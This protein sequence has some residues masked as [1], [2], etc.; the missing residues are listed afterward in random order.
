[1]IPSPLPHGRTARRLEWVHLPPH[2]RASVEARLG[3]PVTEAV[4]QD[5]GFTPGLA[6]VLTC[7]DGTRHF[8]KAASV[9]AQ[10][11]IAE[12]YR[13]EA[14][15]LAALPPGAPAARLAWVEDDAD[16]VVLG[17]EHVEGRAPGRPWTEG[18]LDAALAAL[19]EAAELLTPAPEELRLDPFAEEFAALPAYW[20]RIGE[21]HPGL[22]HLDEAAELAGGIAE[23][24]G[25]DTVVHTDVRDDN[26][27]VR[28]DGRVVLCDWNWPVLGAPWID[29]VMLLIGPRGDGLDV[30]RV[31]TGSVL[32][33]DLPDD[34]VDTLIALVTGHFL[35]CAADPVP[36]TSPHLRTAQRWQGVVCWDWLCERRGWANDLG[37]D[38]DLGAGT[39]RC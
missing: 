33:R 31:L 25:G 22:A 21:I 13:E 24:T 7:A 35:K 38:M 11:P 28:P 8:V 19:H 16:W 17:L 32:T 1:M 15:K 26:L 14:R 29:T 36:A 2:V 9:P 4:S 10:R 6:S 12:A 37:V 34:H 5:A 39:A 3:S 18:D 27:I 23:I 30:G 20:D